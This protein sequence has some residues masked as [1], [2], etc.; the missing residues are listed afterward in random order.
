MSRIKF[1]LQLLLSLSFLFSAYTKWV[2]PGFF[3]ITLL[4]QGLTDSRHFAAIL[5]R[6]VIGLE[7][8][9]GVF[10]L[11]PFYYKKVLLFTLFLLGAFTI[12]L[13]YL[14]FQGDTGNCGCF[15]E[16]IQ[17]SPEESILKNLFLM[18]L[19]GFLFIKAKEKKRRRLTLLFVPLCI[20]SLVFVLLP[21]KKASNFPFYE[22]T[23]FEN[24][25]R[26][27][28]S[29]G[30][31]LVAVFNLDCEHCQEA[32][33]ALGVL[34]Q[35]HSSFPTTYVL[36]FQ[37]GL[38]TVSEF[39]H[40]TNTHFPHVLIDVQQYFDLIGEAPPRI[41]HLN[42]GDVNAIWDHDFTENIQNQFFPK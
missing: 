9:L 20:T 41:Y 8:A 33:T 5:T 34:Q 4:D 39:E 27:D 35:E 29:A 23:H 32:A 28:L 26:V 3:E 7:F 40:S 37:E 15:G 31:N 19:T 14:W 1:L 25:G 18:G 24:K 42:E 22:F 17:M 2:A 16:M 30:E 36:Y 12:H 21:L 11:L 38:T 10:L 6:I 13:M